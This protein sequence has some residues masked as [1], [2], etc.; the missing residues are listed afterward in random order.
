[1]SEDASVEVA[2]SS[3]A[4]TASSA[5]AKSIEEDEAF[6]W[7]ENLAARQGAEEALLLNP[8]ERRETPPDWILSDATEEEKT[9]EQADLK[10]EA[11]GAAAIAALV[12]AHADEEQ[13]V[14]A[15]VELAQTEIEEQPEVELQ[16]ETVVL[17]EPEAPVAEAA[18]I[19]EPTVS[20]T[21]SA[22]QNPEE[23]EE[24][25]VALAADE[26]AVESQMLFY[27]LETAET[28]A[29]AIILDEGPIAASDT[30]PTVV[31]ASPVEAIAALAAAT[32]VMDAASGEDE[33]VETPPAA[34]TPLMSADDSGSQPEPPELPE[35]PG[36]GDEIAQPAFKPEKP[37]AE[38]VVLPEEDE[39]FAWLESLAVR[40]GAEEALLLAPEE[41]QETPPEWVIQEAAET[42]ATQ[43]V[44]QFEDSEL[45]AWLQ[46]EPAQEPE[47]AETVKSGEKVPDWLKEPA[48]ISEESPK[49]PELPPLAPELPTWLAG[50][51][52][53]QK[54]TETTAWTPT[55]ESFVSGEP[56]EDLEL[57]E[58][59]SETVDEAVPASR[60]DL[61]HAG[62]IDLERLP[63]VG[64]TRAQAILDYRQQHGP[65]QEIDELLLVS[66][67]TPDL[68]LDLTQVLTVG[69]TLVTAA[70][71]PPAED[72]QILLM[73]ARN[74]LVQGDIPL[75]VSRYGILIEKQV[76]LPEVITDM[77]EAL[78]RFPI[79][80]SIWEALG[81]A[82]L[83]AG[84]LQ[85][86]LNAYTKAEEYL[87]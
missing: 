9:P 10:A 14:A 54:E 40:Q 47:V 38:G 41:R 23:F 48:A 83:R 13:E 45:P 27:P 57:Q 25:F 49:E 64:F 29:E 52:D 43:P 3:E 7:L 22:Q 33:N 53:T 55:E 68:L 85:E 56:E 76:L 79:D 2:P 80:V 71:E 15:P 81:D 50:V 67:I 75:A 44:E 24:E 11:L 12:T 39:A 8:E 82:Q 31:K 87:H 51:E 72:H 62:L 86:A 84:H 17:P 77:N 20:E 34:P 73:Q 63:G 19:I 78:Y 42:E 18:Q 58:G 35:P 6:A 70:V 36:T 69:G 65:F 4:E 60:L 1:M 66:G 61:N 5:E 26:P 28:A 16:P 32:A 59:H 74:A 21:G 37:I 30:K 46:E